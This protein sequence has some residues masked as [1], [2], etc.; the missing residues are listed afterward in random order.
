MNSLD[1]EFVSLA[2]ATEAA[3]QAAAKIAVNGKP[4]VAQV[5]QDWTKAR[6][7]PV[8]FEFELQPETDQWVSS[9]PSEIRPVNLVEK[10]PRIA[11]NIARVWR[12]PVVCDKLLDE[13][14][15][16]HRGTRQ[17]FPVDVALDILHLKEHYVTVVFPEKRDVWTLL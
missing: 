17:G 11:N 1:F 7:Q 3:S 13:L 16:D 8:A 15:I 10:F 14:L 6:K 12:R 9:L 4:E 5:E 2:E